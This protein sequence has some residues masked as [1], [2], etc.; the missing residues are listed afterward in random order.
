[1][2]R[3]LC[4]RTVVA[5]DSTHM[6]LA[7]EDLCRREGVAGRLIPTPTAIRADC[8]LAW[9]MPPDERPHFESALV[10][11]GQVIVT[12]GIYDLML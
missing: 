9:A 7:C 2:P 4:A 6:A 8:G 12:S 5:F 10:A 3:R 1:M 11:S